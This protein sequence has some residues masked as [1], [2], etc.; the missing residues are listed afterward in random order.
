[1]RVPEGYEQP[2]RSQADYL[3]YWKESLD[4][5]LACL[6]THYRRPDDEGHMYSAYPVLPHPCDVIWNL[7]AGGYLAPEPH[8]PLALVKVLRDDFHP[9]PQRNDLRYAPT[10][11]WVAYATLRLLPPAIRRAVHDQVDALLAHF[12]ELPLATK[13]RELGLYGPMPSYL[14]GKSG[15]EIDMADAKAK[16]R[17]AILGTKLG[18]DPTMDPNR[19]DLGF[20]SYKNGAKL[21]ELL[22]RRMLERPDRAYPIPKPRG[23]KAT[24]GDR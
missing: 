22:E 14:D 18:E 21:S 16:L 24:P 13:A 5:Y 3:R 20:W 12:S 11:R 1:M 15:S 17:M 23:A 19:V 6:R 8:A 4:S 10:R 2:Y 7:T 9:R